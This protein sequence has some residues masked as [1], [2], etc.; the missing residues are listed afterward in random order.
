MKFVLKTNHVRMDDGPV[1]I[2]KQ[3]LK[4]LPKV[5]I[6]YSVENEDQTSKIL[7]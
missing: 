4:K 1:E 7:F 2:L 6:V 3:Y 5:S